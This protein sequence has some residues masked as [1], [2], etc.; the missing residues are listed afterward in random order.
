MAIP[1]TGSR[2]I[3]EAGVK[4]RWRIRHKA[5]H[6]QSDYGIGFL[7]V[8]VELFDAPGTMAVFWTDR[9][10]PAD[11]A[12][13]RVQAITPMDV[14]NWIAKALALSWRPGTKGSPVFFKVIGKQVEAMTLPSPKHMQES[15]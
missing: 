12:T 5:T 3:V 2:C 1:K 13:A 14:S 15:F 9:P 8:A 4:H 7:H 10:H 6:G 11:W